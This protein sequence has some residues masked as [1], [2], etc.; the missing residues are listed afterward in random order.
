MSVRSRSPQWFGEGDERFFIDG[1]EQASIQGTGTEDYFLN[2]WG[3]EQATFPM[4]GVTRVDGWLADLGDTGTM[5]RWHVV[6]AVRFRRSLR[7]TIEHAGWMPT[8]QTTTGRVE[9]SV[10]RG[11]DFATVAFWYQRGQP[12]PF[13]QLPPADARSLPSIDVVHDGESLLAEA[14]CG[15]SSLHLQA[16]TPWTGAT[17]LFFDG[18]EIGAWFE[19]TFQVPAGERRRLVLPVTHS[20]DFGVYRVLL[21]GAPVGKPLDFY[22]LRVEVRPLSLG[23][24]DLSPGPHRIRLECVGRNEHSGGF[25]PGVDSVRLRERFPGKRP[26][27]APP[28]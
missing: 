18:R 17:Q 16:G 13:T 6:D 15:A 1:E 21:D 4:F 19:L 3:M 11:D 20:Y 25:K 27:R 8:D 22:H 9:G 10:E 12:L 7:V 5:Y 26:P 23:E 2:A 24:P 28:G 14:Q